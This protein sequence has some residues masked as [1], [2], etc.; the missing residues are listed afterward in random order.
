MKVM[1]KQ[2]TVCLATGGRI[3]I[4]GF[5]TFSLRFRPVQAVLRSATPA[6]RLGGEAVNALAFKLDQSPGAGRP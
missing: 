2:M 6:T 4:C 5:G 3:E 1:L